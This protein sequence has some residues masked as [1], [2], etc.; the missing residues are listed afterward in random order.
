MTAVFPTR[1]PV[2]ITASVGTST[3]D[4]SRRV[5]AEV[6]PL[7]G[8]SQ[9]EH[10][11]REREPLRRPEHRLVRQVEDQVRVVPFDRDLDGRLERNA[12]AVDVAAQLLGAA[13]E[14]RRDDGRTSSS[15]AARTTGG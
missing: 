6:G 15:S 7:V 1:L 10:P 8:H 9:R 14:D 13:D 3:H 2:P 11:A 12:V 4:G 5:E